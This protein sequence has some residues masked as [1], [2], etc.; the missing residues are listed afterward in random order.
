MTSS[1]EMTVAI[2]TNPRWSRRTK[3]VSAV[4]GALLAGG[5]AFATTAWIVGLGSGSSGEGQSAAV[6]NLTITAVAAPSATYLLYPG[7]YGD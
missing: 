7:G 6:T 5:G 4:V 2:R 1:A 3:A